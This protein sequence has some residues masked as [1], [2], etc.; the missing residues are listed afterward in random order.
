[1]GLY[2][3]PGSENWS[4]EF[5]LKGIGRVR[6]STGTT[7]RREAE[8][9]ERELRDEMKKRV[10]GKV[11]SMTLR[12][13]L[14]RHGVAV[15]RS[16]SHNVKTNFISLAKVLTEDFGADTP[17]DD[18]NAV[19]I[20]DWSEKLLT[21]GK[22][23]RVAGGKMVKTKE[24]MKAS[25]VN[26]YLSFLSGLLTRAHKEWKTLL[27]MPVIKWREDHEGEGEVRFLSVEEEKRLLLASPK[28]LR[29][30]LQFLLG[31]GARKSEAYQ[32][33]WEN[34]FNLQSNAPY[35][36]VKFEHAP[37]K[38]RTTK[39][40]KSR[41]VPLPEP[42]RELLIEMRKEQRESGYT[43]ELVLVYRAPGG[44]WAPIVAKAAFD[45]A[46]QQAGLPDATL[47]WTRHTYA[48]RL[49]KSRV[50]LLNV[51]KLLGHKS[52][53]TTQIYAHLVPD[54]LAEDVQVLNALAA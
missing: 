42:V 43:G 34:V 29:Q 41:I 18:L 40:K 30:L 14:E 27:E 5:E 2:K 46:R 33:V 15:A 39:T 37:K 9:F 22:R 11:T 50:P 47:H 44:V 25:T 31:T 10:R 48:S 49:L 53:V 38:S 8:E 36:E 45:T 16:H 6:R 1:M 17:L 54:T 12:E 32:L 23:V 4:V 7:S 13:A 3:Q 51:S 21:T 24:G 35:A 52:I 26:Q 20:N 28:H 19:R